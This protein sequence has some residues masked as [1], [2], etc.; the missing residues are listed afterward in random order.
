MQYESKEGQNI[1]DVC[2][3][4]YGILDLLLKLVTDNNLSSIGADFY[5]KIFTFDE[6]LIKDNLL[7]NQINIEK[8]NYITASQMQGLLTDSGIQITTDDGT[9]IF[10]D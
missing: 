3:Q 5:F 6:N 2:L 10:V 1:Y 9:N 4:T 8:I 7:F